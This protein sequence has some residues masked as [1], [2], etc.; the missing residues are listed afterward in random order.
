M[1]VDRDRAD[2]AFGHV[3]MMVLQVANQL[4]HGTA[5]AGSR[6]EEHYL[7]H[8]FQTFGHRLVKAFAL[9]NALAVG[10]VGDAVQI[11]AKSM[12]VERRD[13]L[14]HGPLHFGLVDPRFAVVDHDQQMRL[15]LGFGP[16][17]TR[18]RN[19][20]LILLADGSV[21][22]LL[23]TPHVPAGGRGKT[24]D[25]QSERHAD[26]SGGKLIQL[27]TCPPTLIFGTAH[28]RACCV[29]VLA[30]CVP[31]RKHHAPLPLC[32]LPFRD[33][34]SLRGG[35][36]PPPRDARLHRG[37]ADL[38]HVSWS[39]ESS[40]QKKRANDGRSSHSGRSPENAG[41]SPG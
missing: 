16:L 12:R 28:E 34:A 37:G 15:R 4:L 8:A 30:H 11:P 35:D 9:R 26:S 32:V 10:I 38:R 20:M 31:E 3:R 7:P 23:A 36:V 25:R 33:D 14:R 24:H 41:Y 17:L 21:F 27:P 18:R 5:R 2:D 19:S 39:W 40:F 13:P 6:A 29:Y 22:R 1:L